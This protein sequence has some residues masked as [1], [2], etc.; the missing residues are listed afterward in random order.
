MQNRNAVLSEAG[1][2]PER[3]AT[4][5]VLCVQ[6]ASGLPLFCVFSILRFYDMIILSRSEAKATGGWHTDQRGVFLHFWPM[7]G[8]IPGLGG[9][10]R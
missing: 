8:R 6:F 3:E 1:D 7:P 2:E 5:K 10:E 9:I 4:Q